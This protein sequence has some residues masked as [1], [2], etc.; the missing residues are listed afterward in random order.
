V[1]VV[2]VI[3]SLLMVVLTQALWMG[4]N[5]LQRAR[6]D[7]SAQATEMM[8]LGWYRDVV[9]GLQADRVDGAHRFSGEARGF[10]GLS[11]GAPTQNLGGTLPVSVSLEFD[12]ASDRTRLQIRIEPATTPLTLLSWPGRAGEFVFID[13]GGGEFDRWPPPLAIG[14][15]NTEQLPR[16][17]ALKARLEQAGPLLVYT[18][19]LGDL[20]PP[21]SVEQTLEAFGARP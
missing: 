8:R 16:V 19:I 3:V 1:L 12:A 15:V 2:L 18:A 9:A 20:R 14:S 7:M 11:A 6:V 10:T 13:H 4:L 21:P 5:L 17:I